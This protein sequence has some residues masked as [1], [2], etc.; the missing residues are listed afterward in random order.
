MLNYE[1][2]LFAVVGIATFVMAVWVSVRMLTPQ[3]RS[4]VPL[5]SAILIAPAQ[6]LREFALTDTLN[7]PLTRQTLQGHWVLL[8]F[9]YTSCP[10]VCPTILHTLTEVQQRMRKRGWGDDALRFLFVSVDPER[11]EGTRLK[12]YLQ[13]FSPTFLGATGPQAALQGLTGQLGVFYQRVGEGKNYSVNHSAAV[14]L[15]DP[16]ARLRALF[17]PPQQTEK[18]ETDLITLLGKG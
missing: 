9:G 18:M 17:E 11:D 12:E 15:L 10:D 14:F 5:Q 7:V 6:T 4:D 8:T 3:E 13:Y 2:W 1:R 16:Q